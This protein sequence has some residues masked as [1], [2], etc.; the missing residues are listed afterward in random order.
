MQNPHKPQNMSNLELI[1]LLQRITGLTA[2]VLLFVQI[3]LGSNM[4]FWRAKFGSIALKIHIANGLLAYL[5]I[6]LHPTLMIA[7]RY[8]LYQ[9]IDPIYVFTD[10]CILCDGVYEYYINFGRLAFISVTIA[11]F[12]GL[13]RGYDKFMRLNWR[14]FHMLN[15]LAFYF[16]SIHAYNIGTDSSTKLFVYLF[17]F[18]QIVVLYIVL[19]KLRQLLLKLH[20]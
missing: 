16:V 12:A 9:K 18:F 8:L 15:Y 17:W 2:F 14:K 4:D 13:F 3:I 1:N 7:F 20:S 5:F 10:A 11:V 6:F 19:S